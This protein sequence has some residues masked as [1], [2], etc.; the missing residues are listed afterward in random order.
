MKRAPSVFTPIRANEEKEDKPLVFE[1]RPFYMYESTHT[2]RTTHFY[3]S[4][5]IGEP[6]QYVEMIQ[7]LQCSSEHDVI[8]IH[9]NS[10]GGDLTAGVQILNA[11]LTS[12]A[13]VVTSLEGEVASMAAILFLAGDEYIIHD[14]CLFMIHNYSGGAIGKAHEIRDQIRGVD[15]WVENLFK[16]ML[17]PF[18]SEEEFTSLVDGKDMWMSSDEVRTR[19]N[20]M[21][22]LLE[23]QEAERERKK[24]EAKQKRADRKLKMLK[25]EQREAKR[26]L[27][28]AKTVEKEVSVEE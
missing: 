1:P 17:I 21:A 27:R 16:K 28:D 24:E 20:N 2:A 4:T 15:Q 14:D 6:C 26:K 8:F 22:Q 18:V 25:E 10:P 9:L 11:M 5:P 19:L 7:R 13:H 23:D 12:P 3:I